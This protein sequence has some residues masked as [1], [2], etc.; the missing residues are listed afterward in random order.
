MLIRK[1]VFLAVILT[2]CIVPSIAQS[3]SGK[4][5]EVAQAVVTDPLTLRDSRTQTPSLSGIGKTVVRADLL[6]F[7]SG[8]KP[9]RI[10]TLSPRGD[11]VCYTIRSYNFEPVDPSSGIMNLE[12][13]ST[14]ESAAN[15]HLKSAFGPLPK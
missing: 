13:T 7:G 8:Q 6:V 12:G 11:S 4:A 9:I 14:C 5:K 3:A 2:S 10:A 15:A 1:V